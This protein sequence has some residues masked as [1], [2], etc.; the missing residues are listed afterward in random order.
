VDSLERYEVIYKNLIQGSLATSGT[1]LKTT[2]A[3][4][5]FWVD[6]FHPVTDFNLE[7]HPTHC[8][9]IFVFMF[10]KHKYFFSFTFSFL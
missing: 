4:V 1:F 2:S 3:V 5:D 10:V 9:F 6:Y 7:V 8:P